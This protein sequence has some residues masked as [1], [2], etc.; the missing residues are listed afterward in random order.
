[1]FSLGMSIGKKHHALM[2]AWARVCNSNNNITCYNITCYN[3]ATYIAK[4][5]NHTIPNKE[6]WV[7]CFNFWGLEV[8]RNKYGKQLQS[9]EIYITIIRSYAF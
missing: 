8:E 5:Y 2:K 9:E 7:T 3:V 4:L 6:S 1:M